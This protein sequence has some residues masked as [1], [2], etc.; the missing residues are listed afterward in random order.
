MHSKVQKWGNSLA[1]RIPRAFALEVGLKPDGS[2]DVSVHE[3]ALIVAPVRAP[4]YALA[5]LL[6]RVT[7]RNRHSEEHFGQPAGRE[8]W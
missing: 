3:G 4:R 6:A 2:V 8:A 5:D 7:P 1:V